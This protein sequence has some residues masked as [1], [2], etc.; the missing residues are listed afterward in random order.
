M[1][2]ARTT[3]VLDFRR[4]GKVRHAG[5]ERARPRR[6]LTASSISAL[7]VGLGLSVADL[8]AQSI[9]VREQY[10]GPVT[11]VRGETFGNPLIFA[12]PTSI[13]WINQRLVII[14]RKAERMI[15]VLDGRTGSTVQRFG[16]RGSGPGEFQGPW[17]LAPASSPNAVW[18]FDTSLRRMTLVDL[19]Q[20][21]ESGTFAPRRMVQLSGGTELN[22]LRWVADGMLFGTGTLRRG[23]FA[24]FDADGRELPARGDFTHG[25]R[26]LPI[27]ALQQAY[28]ARIA[29]DPRRERIALAMTYAD[30]LE[31]YST[32]GRRV[33]TAQRPVG[34]EPT[35]VVAGTGSERRAVFTGESREAYEDLDATS[36]SVFALF[37][38]RRPREFKNDAMFARHVLVFSWVGVLRGVLELD[39]AA[40]A[41][42][43]D[44]EASTLYALVHDPEPR[45]VRYR[46]P[47]FARDTR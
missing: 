27:S 42:A 28:S 7:G 19:E 4:I 40:I 16:R 41:I 12:S 44:P 39:A 14:D 24:V 21:F 29:T 9:A 15:I 35:F 11:R 17:E 2:S 30:R 5:S 37:S 46:L 31:F 8:P 20:S 36:T 13:E 10:G 38:G 43:V 47:A 3:R 23:L 25:D 1:F 18:I 6:S 26:R 22:S 33:G 34:F 45:V 32:T